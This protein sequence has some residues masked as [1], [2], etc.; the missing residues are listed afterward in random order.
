MYNVKLILEIVT[1]LFLGGAEPRG[2]PELRAPAFRGALRYWLRAALGGTIGTNIQALQDSEASVFGSAGETTG[3][4]SSVFL[5]I[6]R[7]GSIS[8]VSY[9]D[10]A[11]RDPSSR[12]YRKSGLAY[13]FFAARETRQESERKGLMGSFELQISTRPRAAVEGDVFRK[14]WGTLWLLTRFG[15]VGSRS[16]RGAG[17]VAVQRIEGDPRIV[18]DLPPLQ[19]QAGSPQALVAELKEGLQAIRR[20][21]TEQGDHP[22]PPVPAFDT[23]HPHACRVWVVDKVYGDWKQGLDEFGRCYQAFRSRRA[24]D[25][26]TVKDAVRT[27]EPLAQPVQRAAFGLPVPFFYRSLGNASAI[28][29]A[30]E[31]DRRASPVWVRVVRL[32]NGRYAIVLL[33]FKSQFLPAGTRLQLRSGNQGTSGSLPDDSLVDRFITGTDP[34]NHSSLKDK[35]LTVLEVRYA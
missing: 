15:G 27:G 22:L 32:A 33:W 19:I 1:P 6:I 20:L 11:E 16:R 2:M 21:L 35:G 18:Q 7:G 31:Q 25:Y 23:I 34:V 13:L 29:Q 9:S 3:G 5:R 14:A 8:S 4:A 26:Q 17:G 30:E 10:I 12:S 24:P 28:L